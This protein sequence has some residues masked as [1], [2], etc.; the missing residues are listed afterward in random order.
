MQQFACKKTGFKIRV[1]RFLAVCDTVSYSDPR[2][3]AVQSM[4]NCE[5]WW[6]A[7]ELNHWG[8]NKLTVIGSNN[9]LLPGRHQAIIWTNAGILLIRTTF[10]NKL[11]WNLKRNS[12]ILIQENTYENIVCEMAVILS[13]LRCVNTVNFSVSTPHISFYHYG[14]HF[15]II[16]WWACH[17][18]T[19]L[20]RWPMLNA[21]G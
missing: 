14:P 4:L 6:H 7:A 1:R 17:L 2:S 15:T 21:T 11:R 18:N 19:I 12:C 5:N 8:V 3:L 9:G 10:R 13:R 20:A 16:I